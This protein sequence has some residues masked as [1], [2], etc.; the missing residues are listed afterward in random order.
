M[1]GSVTVAPI[2]LNAAASSDGMASAPEPH[3]RT[4][5]R[6][7]SSAP[8]SSSMR[9]IAGTPMNIDA[10]RDSMA[11]S[12][13]TGLKRGRKYTGMPAHASPS[14]AAKP[15]MWATGRAMHGLEPAGDEPAGTAPAR[16][17]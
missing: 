2:F 8:A 13:F 1:T 7:R 6:S 15:M 12:T 17:S 10:R 11:S 3:A 16:A 9:Y 14:S 5:V 4:Q